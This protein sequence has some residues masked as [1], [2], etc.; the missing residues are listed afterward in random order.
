MQD[1]APLH[2]AIVGAGLGGLVAALALARHGH[3][4]QLFERRP[5]FE[6]KGGGIMIR[7]VASRFLQQWGLGPD[8]NAICDASPATL[9]RDGGSGQ[10]LVRNES[11]STFDGSPDW[12]SLRQDLQ[13]LFHKHAVQNGAKIRFGATVTDVSEDDSTAKVHLSTGEIVEVDLLLAADGILSRLRSKIL[14]NAPS[15]TP[16]SSTIYQFQI[17]EDQ[18]LADP[19]AKELAASSDLAVWMKADGGGY[20]VIKCNKSVHRVSGAFGIP[21]RDDDPRLWDEVSDAEHFNKLL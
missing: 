19:N 21:E 2:V 15:P 6:P 20:A 10:V 7:P 9:Y 3:H 8:M 12:G 16:G 11:I 17:P 5:T 4:V 18:V 13:E 1:K 14:S